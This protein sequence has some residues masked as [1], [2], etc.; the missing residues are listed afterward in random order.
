M[1]R[2]LH[3]AD[4]PIGTDAPVQRAGLSAIIP[5]S[6]QVAAVRRLSLLDTPAEQAF[7]RLT[8]LAAKIL[9]APVALLSLLDGERSFFKSSVGMP[10]PWASRREMP[11]SHSVCQHVVA[12]NSPLVINDSRAH[13]LVS[14]NQAV[15][16]L[17]I[18]AYLGI[19][20]ITS[21]GYAFGT[22]A[23]I[24]T[25][26]REWT[27]DD[28]T[29]L[30]DLAASAM[31]EI[32]LRAET[33]QRL[34]VEQRLNLMESVVG[35]TTAAVLIAEAD[36]AEPFE[37]RIVF[38]NDAYTL[39]T[40]YS[41]DEIVGKTYPVLSNSET[42]HTQIDTVRTALA[43]WN[44]ARLE[45]PIQRKDGS[46]LW[47]ELNIVPIADKAGRYSHWVVVQRDNSV[48][49][50]AEDALLKSEAYRQ[51]IL[52]SS[53]DCVI[54]L[55]NQE[56]VTEFNPAAERT[57]GYSRVDAMG[58]PLGELIVP[59][60]QSES[61]TLVLAPSSTTEMNSFLEK[62]LEMTA[63]RADGTTFPAELSLTTI[64]L[65]GSMY[66]VFLRDLTELKRAERRLAAQYMCTRILADSVVMDDTV[67]KILRAV[68]ENM[69]WCVGQMWQL[70][71]K[72]ELLR[73]VAVWHEPAAALAAF[74]DLS[75]NTT[76]RPGLGLPGRVW[77]SRQPHW[78][79]DVVSDANFPRA[80][81]AD[82]CGLH[83]AFAFPILHGETVLGVMEFFHEDMLEPDEPLLAMTAAVGSQVG[84]FIE[85]MRM[86]EA[87]RLR[88]E[89]YRSLVLA[90]S[91]IVWITDDTGQLVLDDSSTW[92]TWRAFTGQTTEQAR[93]AG[94]VNAI[95]PEDR[96]RVTGS[97]AEAVAKNTFY[98]V[99]Y[100]LR[101]AAGE[102]RHTVARGIPVAGADGRVREWI[103]T[104]TDITEQKLAEE[105]LRLSE[106]EMRRLALIAQHTD[107]AVILTDPQG[108]IEWVNDGF[109]RI[110]EY[111]LEE[112]V[113]KTPGSVLQ[114]ADTDPTTMT[115][116]SERLRQGQGFHVEILNYAKSGR[117]YWIAIEV[118][119]ILDGQGNLTRFMSIESDIT[120]RKR[121]DEL[122]K[123]ANQ[124][125]EVR[126]A[127]R[128]AELSEANEF[129]KALLEN[130]QDGIVACNSEGV[131][132]LFN[133]ATREFGSALGVAESQRDAQQIHADQWASHYSLY[134]TDGQT[135]MTT[136]ELPLIRALRGEHI[137][138]VELV[139]APKGG[140]ARI[141]LASGRAFYDGQG[142]KLGAVVSLKDI[143]ER[144][145]AEGEL[146]KAHD[147]LE[148][149]V[150]ARTIELALAK[151]AAEAANRAKSE[152]FSRMSHELR[153]PLNVILGFGQLLE[154]DDLSDPQ[155][156]SAEQIGKGGRHLLALINEIL[157][158]ARIEAG[159]AG[160]VSLEEVD[161]DEVVGEV[162]RMIQ[163][164][165]DQAG[166]RLQA[167]QPGIPG[168]TVRADLQRLKQVLLNLLS[169]GIK[170]NRQGGTV[171]VTYAT[172]AGMR[173]LISVTDTGPGIAPEKMHRLFAP[174]DRL[175][176]EQKGVEGTGLGLTLSKGLVEA[177]QGQMGVE[178]TVGKGSTFWVELPRIDK[179]G[180]PAEENP[181]TVATFEET[182][183]T[184]GTVL[185]VEDNPA[186]FRLVER[187]LKLRPGV[188]LLSATQGRLGI[189][190]A[191]QHHPDVIFLDLHLPDLQGDKVLRQLQDDA[192]TRD[193][194]VIV[195]SADATPHQVERLLAAGANRYLVKP[196][197]VKEF[198]RIL[199]ET[200][201]EGER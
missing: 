46:A 147:E 56:R 87:L 166:V 196:L 194:P 18:V 59:L 163:P 71:P 42:D 34:R 39:L 38:V 161:L 47:T 19:P 81:V 50:A 4:P 3:H 106:A 176:A 167:P 115:H 83:G 193:I 57:F 24:D 20:L 28:V 118:Q 126:I 191:R 150:A 52:E 16:E 22:F 33:N 74:A 111:R 182:P 43:S 2:S 48:Q 145:Q 61:Q 114:G 41:S 54:T 31:T 25:V 132:T 14:D 197:D 133:R 185:Y 23:V 195:L 155:R 101:T 89:R 160:I 75:N 17:R 72:A 136:D 112:V 92:S 139:I 198:L 184:A 105:A 36:L 119:P 29:T 51:A 49:K 103:G 30:G 120:A 149:R 174:F 64:R 117:P 63:V 151:E 8:R 98:Q 69:G 181:L 183:L 94:W 143:T 44:S 122:L 6:T 146:R 107:N 40:G 62:R 66:T 53:P 121:T 95:H 131:I 7:D 177:M 26:P 99:E 138:N 154:L 73:C 188:C 187:I 179:T 82:R 5:Q 60:F 157:D 169:N 76:F 190:L 108:R 153:T 65:E 173:L 109:T 116:M 201:S 77:A 172:T 156:E 27:P 141:L 91:Q 168:W 128:T 200:L 9:H 45:F 142:N 79:S 55:D 97:W 165:A 104:N 186:N 152:F 178:S 170:Y 37:P 189:D 124:E 35:K 70:D 199:D 10:E 144:K 140:A 159:T 21:E 123:E 86:D 192:A 134:R 180:E 90:S 110:C 80:Q 158:I 32:E 88:E 84:Q 113:G 12:L 102:Y 93:G 127:R 125:L 78:V 148:R 100:R 85:R 1:T 15:A 137:Q 11:L 58:K 13:P 129:L 162:L 130:V 68:C 67:P 135:L 96:A 171:A 175:E 164:L